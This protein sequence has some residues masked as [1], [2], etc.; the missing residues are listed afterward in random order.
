MRNKEVGI[1]RTEPESLTWGD[2]TG[3]GKEGRA[4]ES[5]WQG[6]DGDVSTREEGSAILNSQVKGKTVAISVKHS[7]M[8]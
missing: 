3:N 6:K 2:G 8:R 7:R 1:L 5:G 4:E